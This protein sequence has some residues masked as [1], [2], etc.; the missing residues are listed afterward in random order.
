MAIGTPNAP[1]QGANAPLTLDPIEDARG[2]SGGERLAGPESRLIS[3]SGS[4]FIHLA[5]IRDSAR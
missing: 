5:D 3:R 1:R 4:G 2:F